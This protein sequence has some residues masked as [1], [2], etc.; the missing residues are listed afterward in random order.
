MTDPHYK[1]F[2]E[3]REKDYRTPRTIRQ[4]YGYDTYLYTDDNDAKFLD[5][6]VV[7]AV[8]VVVFLLSAAVTVFLL[9]T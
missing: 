6:A 1:P 7:V 2:S 4:A 5:P 8:V 9:W 3:Y